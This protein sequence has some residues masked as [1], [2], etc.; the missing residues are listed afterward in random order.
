MTK[1]KSAEEETLTLISFWGEKKN[2]Q[3]SP[4]PAPR[5]A[6]ASEEMPATASGAVRQHGGRGTVAVPPFPAAGMTMREHPLH[7]TAGNCSQETEVL[8]LENRFQRK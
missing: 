7:G 6:N 2:Q 5:T 3:K 8:K 4:S 1:K